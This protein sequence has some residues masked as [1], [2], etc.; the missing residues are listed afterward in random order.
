MWPNPQFLADLVT[1]SDE[2]LNGKPHFLCSVKL[3]ASSYPYNIYLLKVNNR[4]TKKTC[5]ICPK[6][7]IKTPEPR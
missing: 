5:E 6:L 7:T 1:F 3:S 2:T 4:K